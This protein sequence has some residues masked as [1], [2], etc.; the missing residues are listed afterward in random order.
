MKIHL[1]VD[2]KNVQAWG[3]DMA[4]LGDCLPNRHKALGLTPST[5]FACHPSTQM[6]EVGRKFRSSR[7]ASGIKGI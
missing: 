5:A 3:W 6:A 4:Q 7:S 2:I 1:S